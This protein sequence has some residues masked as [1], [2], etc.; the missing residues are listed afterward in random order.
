MI[1]SSGGSCLHWLGRAKKRR[2]R[3]RRG[4]GDI[5]TDTVTIRMTNEDIRE[6][7]EKMGKGTRVAD[8]SDG[9]GQTHIRD[10]HRQSGGETDLVHRFR[11]GIGHGHPL[12]EETGHPHQLEDGI[13]LTDNKDEDQLHQKSEGEAGQT[14]NAIISGHGEEIPR[15]SILDPQ[16]L[17]HDGDRLA[18][19]LPTQQ[20]EV[21][22]TL[23]AMV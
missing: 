20:P 21:A 11:G 6:G 22:E 2:R 10:L 23:E 16:L 8:Q 9:D 14:G 5:I 4:T 12:R 1:L 17:S 19:A 15:Q 18:D 13:A 3:K 7:G